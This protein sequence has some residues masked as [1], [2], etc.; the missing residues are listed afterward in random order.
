[1]IQIIKTDLIGVLTRFGEYRPRQPGDS[2]TL[3]MKRLLRGEDTDY[4]FLA[5]RE[6]SYLFPVSEVYEPDSFAHLCWTAYRGRP[7]PHVD[8]MY[9]HVTNVVHGWPMGSVIL[10]DYEAAAQDAELFAQHPGKELDAHIRSIT[11][12]YRS[13][14]RFCDM[15]EFFAQL[16]KDGERT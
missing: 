13:Y 2:L 15:E 4:F 14:A 9:L 12:R 3:D 5:R 16:R 6:K 11:G 7:D 8:A 10:L 1:M